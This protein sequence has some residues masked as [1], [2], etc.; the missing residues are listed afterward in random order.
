MHKNQKEG[1]GT[2]RQDRSEFK[3]I[4]VGKETASFMPKKALE[5]P[6]PPVEKKGGR[7]HKFK[8]EW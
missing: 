8:K 1:T 7:N 3:Q 5:S 6:N 2:Y 4:V